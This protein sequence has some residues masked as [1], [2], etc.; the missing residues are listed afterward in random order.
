MPVRRLSVATT[1]LT[2]A[3]V[4]GWSTAPL[5]VRHTACRLASQSPPQQQQAEIDTERER[6]MTLTLTLTRTHPTPNPHQVRLTGAESRVPLLIMTETSPS[7]LYATEG[8]N[9]RPADPR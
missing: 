3:S 9:P 8:S 1:L 4:A 6:E 2:A 5:L 7:Q